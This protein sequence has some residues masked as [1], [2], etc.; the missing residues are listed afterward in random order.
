M[1]ECGQYGSCS[2]TPRRIW[3]VPRDRT[4]SLPRLAVFT[5][6]QPCM[7]RNE[8]Y[9]VALAEGELSSTTALVKT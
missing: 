1:L 8:F 6:V 3:S 2:R 4:P 5:P 7:S 9:G